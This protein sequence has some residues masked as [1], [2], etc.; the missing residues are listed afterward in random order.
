M[1]HNHK[2][3]SKRLMNIFARLDTGRRL[4]ALARPI[5]RKERNRLHAIAATNR[6]Q[7]VRAC[8][9][10]AET[11]AAIMEEKGRVMLEGKNNLDLRAEAL[12]LLRLLVANPLD[13]EAARLLGLVECEA[14]RRGCESHVAD[15]RA[16]VQREIQKAA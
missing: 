14:E 9:A 12:R 13:V 5:D 10:L 8:E 6:Y 11:L 2:L 3:L 4:Q 15:M 1:Q 7:A 16:L